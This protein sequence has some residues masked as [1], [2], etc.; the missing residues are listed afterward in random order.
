MKI[1]FKEQLVCLLSDVFSL[2]KEALLPLISVPPNPDLGD[3]AMPCFRFAKELKKSPPTIAAEYAEKIDLSGNPYFS[4]VAAEGAYLNF[5]VNREA[6]VE[7]VFREVNEKG[8]DYGRQNVGEGKVVTIDYSSPNIAKEFHIGHL[9]TTIIGNALIKIYN[10]LGYKTYGLNFLGDWGTQFGKMVVAYEEWGEGRE[11]ETMTLADLNKI[12]VKFHD[13]ADEDPSYEDKARAAYLK[14]QQGDPG[15]LRVQKAVKEIS[16]VELDAMYKRM[17]VSFDSYNG[18]QYYNDKMQ[19]VVDELKEKNLLVE[20]EGAMVVDLEEFKLPPSLILR[21]DGGTLYP[22]RDIAAAM[23]RHKVYGFH[24]SLYV[25]DMR[26]SLHFTQFFKVL[27]L[28]G[29]EFAKDLVHVPYGLL[30]LGDGS[31]S[32]RKGR[33]VLLNDL[34]DEAAGRIRQIITERNP[35]LPNKEEVAEQ[36]GLG[37]IYFS[38]LYNSRIKD[39]VFSWDRMLNPEGET[40]PYVQYT[41]ARCAGVIANVG[42]VEEKIDYSLI[43]DTATFELAG[44]IA[45]FPGKVIEAAD[46]NEP[47]IVSRAVMDISQAFNKF[48]NLNH[49]A[50][51]EPKLKAARLAAVKAAKA[52]IASGLALLGIEAP[53]KM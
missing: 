15:A 16:L 33:V 28:M 52:A 22:T 12:Y 31:L 49:V 9:Y 1:D 4:R 17:K 36:V 18:E 21:R 47:F 3:F 2:E 26:Q 8:F 13:K 37:A 42:E 43:T 29:H 14:M 27:E 24:K 19:M 39:S 38:A 7:S 46:K 20:S 6:F 45:A 35:D 30:S 50:G 51:S 25:T 40:G 11:I 53:E 10:K 44:V 48:Y 34:F 41:H 23:D 5:Y 32:T